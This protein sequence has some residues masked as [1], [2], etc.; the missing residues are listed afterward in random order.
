MQH[1]NRRQQHRSNGIRPRSPRRPSSALFEP[2]AEHVI[3]VMVAPLHI[4]ETEQPLLQVGDQGRLSRTSQ[5]QSLQPVVL[6]WEV[7]AV[8]AHHEIRTFEV[9]RSCLAVAA[10]EDNGVHVVVDVVQITVEEDNP[11]QLEDVPQPTPVTFPWP[12]ATAKK[13]KR[14][15]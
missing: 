13:T 15:D 12:A 3:E 14:K 8:F 2:D 10:W 11:V 5:Q 1:S 6:V 4:H 9:C 7:H